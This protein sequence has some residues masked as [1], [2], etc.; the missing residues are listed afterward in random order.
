M[1]PHAP[2]TFLARAGAPAPCAPSATEGWLDT[3][4]RVLSEMGDTVLD[5]VRAAGDCLDRHPAAEGVA[6]ATVSL[7]NEMKVFPKIVYPT[8]SGASPAEKQFILQTLDSLPLRDVSSIKSLLV[9]PHI[10]DASGLAIPAQVTNVV[11]LAHDQISL[12]PAWFRE[13]LIHEAGHTKD[14]DSAWFGV[15]GHNSTRD[16]W[17]HGPFVS[18]Y[19]TTNHWEDYAEAHAD[20]HRQPDH[21][22]TVALEKYAAMQRDEQPT[23][24]DRDNPPT[25][26]TG[27]GIGDHLGSQVVRTGLQ[28]LSWAT[29]GAQVLHGLDD[30]RAATALQDLK[31]H[32][33][34]RVRP[35]ALRQP[36][37]GRGRSGG[38]EGESSRG[39]R[40]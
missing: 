35:A 39:E 29:A 40:N 37:P 26:E 2:H 24:L 10:P 15:L 16:P 3:T 19:A 32:L 22:Q 13:V 14:C 4:R 34:R 25:R 31:R 36:G 5:A 6:K 23:L 18:D 21:L 33:A 30:V 17:G 12:G 1:L 28:T 7:S 27:K 11:K 38:D 20:Y 9:V 8:I